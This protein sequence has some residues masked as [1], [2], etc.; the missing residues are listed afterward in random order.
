MPRGVQRSEMRQ[1]LLD[2]AAVIIHRDGIDALTVQSVTAVANC[3]KGVLY[4]YFEDLDELVTDLV[5]DAFTRI[6]VS[7]HDIVA[8]G[9]KRTV[10]ET[11]TS[12]ATAI[13]DE[14][15]VRVAAAAFSR[16]GVVERVMERL[17][18]DELP[19]L[20]TLVNLVSGYL[21]TEQKRRRVD[22]KADVE[23]IAHLFVSALHER[24]QQDETTA[25]PSIDRIITALFGP[26]ITSLVATRS[27]RASRST[28]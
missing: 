11:V 19:N 26:I 3:A 14:R 15:N 28:S 13:V 8:H 4:N 12:I 24:L 21:R 27:T 23:A 7:V 22:S 10:L 25:A 2:A 9:A 1:E 17:D 16:P 6:A 5:G 20:V 18:G